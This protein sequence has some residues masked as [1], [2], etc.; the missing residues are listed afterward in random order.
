MGPGRV[1]EDVG[2]NWTGEPLAAK[3]GQAGGVAEVGRRLRPGQQAAGPD[4]P[5]FRVEVAFGD[6]FVGAAGQRHPRSADPSSPL[7]EPRVDANHR[8]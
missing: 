5:W 2:G 1:S 7:A 6:A 8:G 3:G 4:R